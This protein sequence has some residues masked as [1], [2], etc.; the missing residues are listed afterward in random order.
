MRI[1]SMVLSAQACKDTQVGQ[2]GQQV[3]Q[4][5]YFYSELFHLNM[6][7][8]IILVVDH[9]SFLDFGLMEIWILIHILK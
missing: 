8:F 9:L 7:T 4:N 2:D 3:G 1:V 6:I 5:I